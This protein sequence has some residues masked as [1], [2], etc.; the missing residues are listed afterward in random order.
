MNFIKRITKRIGFKSL[1]SGDVHV[2][3]GL[4]ALGLNDYHQAEKELELAVEFGVRKYDLA[5][6]YTILGK[7]YKNLGRLDEAI[8]THKKALTVNPEYHKA[9]NNLGIAYLE[10]NQYEEAEKCMKRAVE[11]DPSYTFAQASLGAVYIYQ[12]KPW[13]AVKVLE[14]AVALNARMGIAYGNLALAYA[15]MSRFEEARQS[16]K[17]ATVLG[18]ENWQVIGKRIKALEKL[19]ALEYEDE[20]EDLRISMS[21]QAQKGKQIS[22]IAIQCTNC[23]QF[24]SFSSTRCVKCGS[25]LEKLIH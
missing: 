19:E 21:M 10:I 14:K 6:I 23:G 8:A 20:L 7:T 24:N 18:Y 2:S 17:K 12:E 1:V 22:D 9:W 25:L 5:E 16:L 15:L 4:K 3:R 11:L 13:E